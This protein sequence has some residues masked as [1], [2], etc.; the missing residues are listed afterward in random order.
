MAPGRPVK[1]VSLGCSTGA[2]LYSLVWLIRT[3]RPAQQIQALGID[4]AEECV[5]AASRGVYPFRVVEVAGLSETSHERFFSKQGKTLVVQDWVKE[6]VSWATGDACSPELAAR[7]GLQ[8]VVV[9][10][11]FLSHMSAERAEGCL[12]NLARLVAPNGVLVVSGA[13]LDVRTKFV[14]ELGFI[15]VTAKCEEIYAAEDVHAAWPL[16]AWGLEPMDRT[17][18]DWPARYVTLFRAPPMVGMAK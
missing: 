3:A 18:E 1:I 4:T 5:Q 17:H 16:Y 14:R 2:E 9:A 13:D 8:D 15:P 12:R 10:N 7:F 6:G 11:N